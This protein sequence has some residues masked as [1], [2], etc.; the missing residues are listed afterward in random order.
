MNSLYKR[1]TKD[2]AHSEWIDELSEEEEEVLRHGAAI[3]NYMRS[4]K[5][6]KKIKIGMLDDLGVKE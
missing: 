5:A 4:G 1:K 2:I 6:D 3:D